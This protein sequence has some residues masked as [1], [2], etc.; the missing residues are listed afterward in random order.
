MLF[1]KTK[2][3][4]NDLPAAPPKKGY[5]RSV[6]KRFWQNPLSAWAA[7]ILLLLAGIA[8]FAD[9][10]ANE[11]PLYFQR[12]GQH[13][14]PVLEQY[15]E[16]LG[17]DDKEIAISEEKGNY[18]RVV[19]PLIPFGPRQR[20]V[21]NSNF[22]P[23]NTAQDAYYTDYPHVHYL[24]TDE[25]GR[26][27]AAGLVHGTRKALLIGVLAMFLATAIGLV[28]GAL[29]G[30]FGDQ[31]M[32]IYR[33]QALLFLFFF[34]W[35]C[36]YCFVAL[37]E[38]LN[39]WGL[40]IGLT[41]ILLSFLLLNALL[42]DL[43]RRLSLRLGFTKQWRIPLDLIVTR[44]IEIMSSLPVLLLVLA[45]IGMLPEPSIWNI[46]FIIG[47]VSWPGI[48]RFTRQEFLRIRQLEYIEAAK[49]FGFSSLRIIFRHA[50]P[51]ALGPILV[52]VA[53]GI[54]STVLFEA[55]ISFLGIGLDEGSATWGQMLEAARGAP[56]A[57][58]LAILPGLAIFLTVTVFNL[59][60]EGLI[61]AMDPK[62]KKAEAEET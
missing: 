39:G 22:T 33:L 49:A 1:W 53:F 59:L 43:G 37:W 56:D 4:L 8:L 16:A 47:L 17:L 46:M 5:W 15:L 58:W 38:Y 42:L 20:D 24:G 2:K 19:F 23:P 45:I 27:V 61:D 25:L 29:G 11:E 57:W 6:R 26:D 21:A 9:F 36:F 35:I 54:A 18:E 32:R 10:I 12:D 7:R 48:A 41:S 44:L 3:R 60:G 14:F 55:F 62:L 31:G 52:A 28:V 13:Y 30:Y 34:P 51:N 40:L 50:L